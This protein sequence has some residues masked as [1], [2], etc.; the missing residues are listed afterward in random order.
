MRKELIFKHGVP[1]EVACLAASYAN[2]HVIDP[3]DE[4]EF[5]YMISKVVRW[6]LT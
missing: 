3:Q 4:N 5:W 6:A 2:K 1:E